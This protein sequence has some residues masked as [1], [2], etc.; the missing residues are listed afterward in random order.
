M[1][2]ENNTKEGEMSN[3]FIYKQDIKREYELLRENDRL[4]FT[5]LFDL[6]CFLL[7]TEGKLDDDHTIQVVER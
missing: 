3:Y 7:R 6:V 2:V 5:D 1:K 4:L